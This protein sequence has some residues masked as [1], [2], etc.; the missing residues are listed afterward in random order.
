M[1]ANHLSEEKIQEIAETGIEDAASKIHLNECG[2]C[3]SALSEYNILFSA[4][5]SAALPGLSEN[6][7]VQAAEKIIAASQ[8]RTKNQ[9]FMPLAIAASIIAGMVSMFVVL[10]YSGLSF[11]GFGKQIDSAFLNISEIFSYLFSGNGILV[12]SVVVVF[13][14][15]LFFDRI[16][17]LA[18]AGEAQKNQG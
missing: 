9:W 3:R 10:I 15:G 13:V 14:F 1:K 6:F 4:I 12:L 2:A 5:A 11:P 18:K 16:I 17:P 7:A 8:A